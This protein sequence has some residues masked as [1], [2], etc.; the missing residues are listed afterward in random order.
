MTKPDSATE[1][2]TSQPQ[3]SGETDYK[4]SA[5]NPTDRS[6]M[7]ELRRAYKKLFGYKPTGMTEAQLKHVVE[8]TQRDRQV[9]EEAKATTPKWEDNVPSKYVR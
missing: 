8:S 1:Q 7:A 4:H 9:K 3:T 5:Y 2:P 6:P